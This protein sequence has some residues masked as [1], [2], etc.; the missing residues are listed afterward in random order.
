MFHVYR[1]IQIYD[2]VTAVVRK[3]HPNIKFVGMCHSGRGDDQDGVVWRTF[4]NQSEHREGTPWPPDAVSFHMYIA[5][6][7]TLPPWQEWS[8]SLVQQAHDILPSAVYVTTL[9]K[10]LSPSTSVFVDEA[11]ICNSCTGS[12]KAMDMQSTIQVRSSC[13]HHI[14]LS[15]N[16]IS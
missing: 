15:S 5:M 3:N 14:F 10:Q 2:G 6:S 7:G 1:Y 4:L 16:R 12:V 8:T 13:N 9:I 11:G